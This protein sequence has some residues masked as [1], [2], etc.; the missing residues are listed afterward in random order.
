MVILLPAR[1]LRKRASLK[2]PA[3]VAKRPHTTQAQLHLDVTRML[4]H[5]D[6]LAAI[7]TAVLYLQ[8]I[9]LP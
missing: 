8:R 3:F 5:G 9:R 2:P 4:V 7:D 1:P 6:D